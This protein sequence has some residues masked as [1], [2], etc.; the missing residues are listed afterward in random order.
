MRRTAALI[1]LPSARV[2][3]TP[4]RGLRDSLYCICQQPDC[5]DQHPGVHGRHC[6]LGQSLP[7]HCKPC[8][9]A[10][11]ISN[12]TS[13]QSTTSLTLTLTLTLNPNPARPVPAAVRRRPGGSGRRAGGD[14]RARAP[15]PPPLRQQ[16]SLRLRRLLGRQGQPPQPPGVPVRRKAALRCWFTCPVHTLSIGG[17]SVSTCCVA[18]CDRSS[19]HY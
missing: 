15:G 18:M 13:T 2:L 10:P 7:P 5:G 12:P 4:I 6:G 8:F 3:H 9:Q 14:G 16:R 11:P 1:V 17:T 19:R